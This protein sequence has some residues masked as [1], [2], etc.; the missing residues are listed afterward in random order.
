MSVPVLTHRRDLR[1][2]ILCF[3]RRSCASATRWI[4]NSTVSA[5][6]FSRRCLAQNW[7]PV[8]CVIG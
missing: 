4:F 1:Q 6:K 7:I 8:H 3:R 5:K 2:G